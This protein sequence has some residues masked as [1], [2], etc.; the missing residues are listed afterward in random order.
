MMNSKLLFNE[1]VKEITLPESK[2]ELESIGYAVLEDLFGLS[3][4]NIFS[5]KQVDFSSD[6]KERLNDILQRINAH[7]PIQY[8]LGKAQFYGRYFHVNSSVLIPR[9]ETEEVIREVLSVYSSDAQIKI[10][11]I[12]TGSGCIPITLSL[13][14][15][16]ANVYALDI[17]D[18]ALK[19]AQQNNVDLHAGVSFIQLDILK[20]DL[21]FQDLDVIVS[22]PPY[23]TLKEKDEMSKNVLAHEPHLALFVPDND[24][25]IFHK[26][27]VAQANK[28]LKNNGLL[29]VEINANY[30]DDVADLFQKFGF[31][32]IKIVKDLSGKNRIVKGLKV[33]ST[34]SELANK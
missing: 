33:V 21:P 4:T 12:G 31:R 8:I 9:P 32:N 25:L 29:C 7:E 11:D 24:P 27:I 10:L 5:E 14:L 26:I 16:K 23:I 22:N 30:G 2:D 28:S 18:E 34:S 17:S 3:V 13:E 15:K 1:F 6:K 19:T 20:L